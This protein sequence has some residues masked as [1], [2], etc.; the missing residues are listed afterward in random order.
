MNVRLSQG[1]LRVRVSKEEASEALANGIISEEFKL[2]NGTV[3]SCTVS[4]VST[5]ESLFVSLTEGGISCTVAREAFLAL[6]EGGPSKEEV[7][8]YA[9]SADFSYIVEIDLFSFKEKRR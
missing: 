9:A 3:F 8:T 4:A 1:Q 7:L 5:P 2:P 6:L